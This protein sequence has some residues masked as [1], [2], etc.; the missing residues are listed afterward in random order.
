[1]SPRQ[2]NYLADRPYRARKSPLAK[3]ILCASLALPCMLLT[4]VVVNAGPAGILKLRCSVL[5]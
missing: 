5:G 3:A 1:M 2:I 4:P